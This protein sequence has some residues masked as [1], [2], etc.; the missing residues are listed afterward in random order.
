VLTAAS[1]LLCGCASS[2]LPTVTADHTQAIDAALHLWSGFP[3]GSSARPLVLAGPETINPTSAGNFTVAGA[4]PGGSSIWHQQRLITAAQA[5]AELRGSSTP[6]GSSTSATLS[7]T[8]ARLGTAIFATDRGQRALPAWQFSFAGVRDVASVLAIAPGNR[9]P[10]TQTPLEDH[11]GL[12]ARIAPDG[13]TVTIL[14]L[15]GSPDPGPCQTNYQ[16]DTFQSDTAVLV[17]IRELPGTAS[18]PAADAG[19]PPLA[20]NAS[21]YP[22]SVTVTLDSVLAGRVLIDSYGAPLP[23]R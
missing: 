15:G 12:A 6:D 1:V 8:A 13:N 23:G 4:L 2:G 17:A 22:R 11:V 7:I 18:Q 9:W 20:C 21:G 3:A 16:A 10:R 19:D 5:L 14:F